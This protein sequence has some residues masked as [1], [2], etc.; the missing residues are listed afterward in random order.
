MARQNNKKNAKSGKKKAA[1]RVVVHAPTSS[2][3]RMT[4]QVSGGRQVIQLFVAKQGANQ[5]VLHPGNIPWLKGVAPNYQKWLLKDVQVWYEPRV[6]TS[7]NGIVAMGLQQDF[8]DGTPNTLAL[9]S[10]LGGA[11]RGAVWDK[12]RIRVPSGKS[13]DYVSYPKFDVL[14]PVDKT[15]RALGI[16]HLYADVD[17][18]MNCGYVYMSYSVQFSDPIDPS[19][20]GDAQ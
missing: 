19:L 6:S 15:D 8:A 20:Q 14:D 18:A 13:R 4:T 12:L 5:F 10:T 9:L 2:S 3:A 17:T 11:T 1:P 16:V 7:T